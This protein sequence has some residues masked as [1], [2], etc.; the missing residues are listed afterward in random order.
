[1][2]SI[3]KVKICK[4]GIFLYLIPTYWHI[5]SFILCLVFLSLFQ[6]A[7]FFFFNF[8]ILVYNLVDFLFYKCV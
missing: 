8:C 2:M 6:I 7:F 5:H 3:T 1:M 4:V